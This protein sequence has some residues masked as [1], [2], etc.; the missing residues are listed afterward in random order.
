M[1]VARHAVPGKRAQK[2]PSRRGRYDRDQLT[3]EVFLVGMCRV[4]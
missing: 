3:A 2:E 1:L 4:S